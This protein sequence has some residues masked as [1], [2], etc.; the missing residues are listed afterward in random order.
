MNYYYAVAKGRKPGIYT[1]WPDAE[2]QVTG[3]NGAVHKKFK[4]REEAEAFI[5]NPTYN[6]PAKPSSSNPAIQD[7]SPVPKNAIIVY[8]DG[9]ALGNPGPGG[10][11]VVIEGG[12]KISKGFNLTTNNRMELRAVISA[13]KKLQESIKPIVI[14]S[15]SKYVIDAINKNWVLKWKNN[16]WIKPNGDKAFNVD[17]WIIFLKYRK[18]LDVEFRWVKGHAG[19]PLNEKAD[20]LA[21][22]AARSDKLYDDKGYLAS[23]EAEQNLKSVLLFCLICGKGK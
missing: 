7:N 4:S 16:N 20:Q 19:H 12:G 17:L 6:N 10:Y 9:C 2:K 14:Y 21:N 1:N 15:D 11:G 23:I 22:A 8:T 18:K 3:F 5:E 13:L